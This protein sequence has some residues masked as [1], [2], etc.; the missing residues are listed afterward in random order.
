MLHNLRTVSI[1]WSINIGENNMNNLEFYKK[2]E[3]PT[4]DG[5]I[6]YCELLLLTLS[7]ISVHFSVVS[8]KICLLINISVTKINSSLRILIFKKQLL[9][10]S[11]P[12]SETK[13]KSNI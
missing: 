6:I 1:T 10:V 8:P 4:T 7:V 9:S 5:V 2:M 12:D 13:F 3:K 11:F